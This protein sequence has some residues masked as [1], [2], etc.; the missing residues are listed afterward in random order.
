MLIFFKHDK[1]TNPKTTINLIILKLETS[2]YEKHNK[3]T[4]RQLI[5]WEK[6]ST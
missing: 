5:D 3:T 2:V 6:I 1:N 4:K